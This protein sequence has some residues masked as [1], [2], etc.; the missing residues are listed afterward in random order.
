MPGVN[1]T[2]RQ[3]II[4]KYLPGE[5]PDSLEDDTPLLSSGILDSLAAQGL[6][7]FIEERY[8][9][10]LDVYDL[11]I[12]RFDRLTDIVALITSKLARATERTSGIAS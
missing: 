7:A 9:I 3:F 4:A 1:D 8:G 12:D 6:A 11:G 5:S 10:E 2:L